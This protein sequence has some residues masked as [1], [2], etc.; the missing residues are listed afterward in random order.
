MKRKGLLQFNFLAKAKVA[1]VL[2]VAEIL[3]L[4][5]GLTACGKAKDPVIE[6]TQQGLQLEDKA[7]EV[8]GQQGEQAE[9]ADDK[10]DSIPTE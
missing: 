1:V 7:R 4:F 9:E 10:L 5:G 2:L 3:M 6:E 8:T